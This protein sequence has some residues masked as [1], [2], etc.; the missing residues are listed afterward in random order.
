MN[1]D[2]AALEAAITLT[3]NLEANGVAGVNRA[4]IRAIIQVAFIEFAEGLINTRAG[5]SSHE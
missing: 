3:G 1:V 2:E 5:A 4:Q